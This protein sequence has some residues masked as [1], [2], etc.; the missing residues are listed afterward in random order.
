MDVNGTDFL[1]TEQRD[2]SL[3]GLDLV[4]ELL[5]LLLILAQD[6]NQKHTG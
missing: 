4:S 2:N 3:S 6:P 5:I 1:S